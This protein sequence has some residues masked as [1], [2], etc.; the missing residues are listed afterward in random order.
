MKQQK[1]LH[2]MLDVVSELRIGH[3][4]AI[5]IRTAGKDCA[6]AATNRAST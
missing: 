6:Q 1:D 5:A 3:I 4:A 2:A